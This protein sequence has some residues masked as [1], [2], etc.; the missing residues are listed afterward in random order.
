M[1]GNIME[2]LQTLSFAC[3]HHVRVWKGKASAS[4]VLPLILKTLGMTLNFLAKV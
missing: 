4:S 3:R 2:K 1:K